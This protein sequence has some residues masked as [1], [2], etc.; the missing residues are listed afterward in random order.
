MASKTAIDEFG[1]YPSTV[2]KLQVANVLGQ[3]LD[4]PASVIFDS[5]DHTG[6]LPCAL[7]NRRRQLDGDKKKFTWKRK[8]SLTVANKPSDSDSPACAIS[9]AG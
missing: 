9:P 7:D 1:N 2:Q 3:L 8:F 5:E 6:Y 4:L